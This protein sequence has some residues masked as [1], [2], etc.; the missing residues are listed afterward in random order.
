MR[1]DMSTQYIDELN[2]REKTIQNLKNIDSKQHQQIYHEVL[3][4]HNLKYSKNQNGIFFNLEDVSTD[5]VREL[6]D[7]IN[8]LIETES[9]SKK[10]VLFKSILKD[11]ARD[12][13]DSPP[14]KVLQ[15]DN[16]CTLFNECEQVIVENMKNEQVDVKN[17]LLT[18]E[19]ERSLGNRKISQNKYLVAKKRF[20]KPT[21]L[22]TRNTYNELVLDV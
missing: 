8:L 7:Y 12:N 11:D 17:I 15:L 14:T 21:L 6:H 9:K 10:D 5:I 20:S 3:K 4:K 18:L 1:Q 16:R 22:D 13:L 2:L 19:K